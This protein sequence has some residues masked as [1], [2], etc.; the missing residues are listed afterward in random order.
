MDSVVVGL[1][2]T[3]AVVAAAVYAAHPR[4]MLPLDELLACLA[5]INGSTQMT[6][7][8]K[9][10][11]AELTYRYYV[12]RPVSLLGSVQDVFP[13]GSIV[14]QTAPRDLPAVG[15][16]LSRVSGDQLRGIMKGKAITL[17]VKLPEWKAF[18]DV[19]ELPAGFRDANVYCGGRWYGVKGTYRVRADGSN[20]LK[21]TSA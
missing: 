1:L 5:R 18:A 3:A 9:R 12:G 17:R 8:Q 16:E 10:H 19:A 6:A 21:Y 7:V 4:K 13:N 20:G 15:I 2:V 11:E 14:M